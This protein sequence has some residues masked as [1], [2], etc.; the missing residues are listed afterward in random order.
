[1]D[2]WMNRKRENG[3]LK[4]SEVVPIDVSI[5]SAESRSGYFPL[6]RSGRTDQ[7]VL[8]WN[9]RVLRTGSD[10]NGPAHGSEPLSSLAPVGQSAGIGRVTA[11]KMDARALDFSFFKTGR[12]DG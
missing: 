7:S 9:A 6:V 2:E 1:M 11:G 12:L 10:Q 4:M 3:K 8:K 5:L